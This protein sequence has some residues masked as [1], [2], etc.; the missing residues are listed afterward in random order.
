MVTGLLFIALVIWFFES[1]SQR[2][3]LNI[4]E[5]A[6]RKLNQRIKEF[7][8]PK[9]ESNYKETPKKETNPSPIAKKI[10][11]EIKEVT[12]DEINKV[13]AGVENIFTKPTESVT[14]EN[15]IENKE[16]TPPKKS[17]TYAE[18]E[19]LIGGKILNRIGALALII[20][21]GFF[22]KYAFDNNWITEAMRVAIG[23]GTGAILLF[24]GH[25]YSKKSFQIFSQGLVGAGI[26]ILYLSAY[27][28]FNYYHL[29]SQSVAIGIMSVV[30][31]VTFW[32]AFKYN[33]IVIAIFGW[34][35]GFI[36]PFLV[37]TGNANEAGLFTYI[38]LLDVGLLFIILKKEKWNVLEPLTLAATIVVYLLWFYIDYS[39]NKLLL[40]VFFLCIFWLLFLGVELTRIIN[41]ERNI[42]LLHQ[43]VSVVNASF[44]FIALFNIVDSQF[45]EWMGAVTVVIATIYLLVYLLIKQKRAGEEWLLIR[46]L[47]SVILLLTIAAGIQYKNF[48][49]SIAWAIESIALAAVA[50]RYK[51]LII[52]YSALVLLALSFLNFIIS[53]NAFYMSPQVFHFI[54]NWR[55]VSLIT[56]MSASIASYY[57]LSRVQNKYSS[58]INS[59]LIYSWILFFFILLSIETKDKFLQ[60]AFFSDNSHNRFYLYIL[61][62]VLGILWMLFAVPLMY[63]GLKKKIHPLFFSGL[64]VSALSVLIISLRSLLPADPMALYYPIVNLRVLSL[65]V[66]ITGLFIQLR[67]M[68]KE[69]LFP[70]FNELMGGIRVTIAAVILILITVETR[71]V[72]TMLGSDVNEVWRRFFSNNLVF[73]LS[74]EWILLAIPVL[75]IA[76]K[77]NRNELFFTGLTVTGAAILTVMVSDFVSYNPIELFYP[78]LNMRAVSLIIISSCIFIQTRMIEKINYY[79]W[80]HIL[81]N[82]MRVTLVTLIFIFITTDTM[83][84]F[85]KK[86]FLVSNIHN[87]AISVLINN[88]RN[89]QQLSISGI[90]LLYSVIIMVIG[91]YRSRFNVR[92]ASI[93]VFGITI[94]KVFFF[95][96]SNL[97][98]LHRIISFM[99]LGVILIF[100]SFLYQRFKHLIFKAT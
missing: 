100:V 27:S 14:F 12:I 57:L 50:A 42:L 67:W 56:M 32:Q 77:K 18:W 48:D 7:T 3:R 38:A 21:M 82:S 96:L 91:I 73:M 76:I 97:D 65:S 55:L 93:I 75:Y 2:T 29:V 51:N 49:L 85:E 39:E 23:I 44:F 31:A 98:T 63:F 64:S 47:L 79:P 59:G 4:L 83:D 62:F 89:Q 8:L 10:I 86:I 53:P 45:H 13:K 1:R 35:G 69:I 19:S 24:S 81:L 36:T 16:I 20:G 26:A 92:I 43:F 80:I 22:L 95:D 84:F 52:V 66:I 9:E 61:L 33:S 46:Y 11:P 58:F 17:R 68:N 70:W 15:I 74:I 94:V 30:T 28:S 71:D 41:K 34:L 25:Y 54:L 5:D 6:V 60:L 40:T 90:W 87:S 72:F 37:S 78:L 88:Y 99:A